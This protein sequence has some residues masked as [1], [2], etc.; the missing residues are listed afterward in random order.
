MYEELHNLYSSSSIVP[1]RLMHGGG[2]KYVQF[3]SGKRE[4]R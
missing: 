2:E 3:F 1:G 4:G